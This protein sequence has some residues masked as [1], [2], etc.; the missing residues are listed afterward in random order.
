MDKCHTIALQLPERDA[1]WFEALA[2]GGDVTADALM[3]A[4]LSTCVRGHAGDVARRRVE[5]S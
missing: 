2:L 1:E 5:T 3:F 4:V